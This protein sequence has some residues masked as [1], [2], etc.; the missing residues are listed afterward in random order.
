MTALD[1]LRRQISEYTGAIGADQ[2]L[3][4]HQIAASAALATRPTPGGT[5]M[6]ATALT[7][8]QLLVDVRR[9]ARTNG[10]SLSWIG[11]INATYDSD[12]TLAVGWDES[13]LRVWRK[14]ATGW[15]IR[16]TDYAVA[17]VRQAVD[18]LAALGILPPHLSSAYRA[19]LAVA[20]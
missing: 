4:A 5:T 9:W 17:S 10:W 7:D 12:A 1:L 16:S 8:R 2:A 15:P 20:R 6:P 14:G 13:G 11:W 19:A 18:V 3:L